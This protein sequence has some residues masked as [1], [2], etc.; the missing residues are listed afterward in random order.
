MPKFNEAVGKD[1]EGTPEP[2]LSPPK[3]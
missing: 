3:P 1:F 2:Q